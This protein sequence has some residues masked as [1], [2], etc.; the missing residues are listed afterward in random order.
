MRFLGFIIFF[1][2]FFNSF[3]Q[4]TFYKLYSGNG[5]DKGEGIVQLPD[6]SYVLTGSSG[7]FAEHNQTYLLAVDKAGNYM[8][9]KSY[10]GPE[11]DLGKRVLHIPNS[12]Y[13]IA[14]ISNSYGQGDFDAFLIKTD[15]NGQEEWIKNYEVP[16]SWEK[17]NDATLTLDSG[18]VMVGE[19]LPMSNGNSDIYLIRTDK[20]GDTLW[21]KRWGT[22]GNEFA[23]SIVNKGTGFI[24][25]GQWYISDSTLVK[26]LLLEIDGDGNEIWRDTI[27]DIDGSYSITDISISNSKIYV[28]GRNETPTKI[29]GYF[30]VFDLNG[31]LLNQY[32]QNMSDGKNECRQVVYNATLDKV[33]VSYHLLNPGTYQD[34]YDLVYAYFDSQFLYWMN[35]SNSVSNEGRDEVGQIIPTSDGGFIGVGFSHS[36]GSSA[37][38]FNGGSHIYLFKV[39]ASNVFPFTENVV[40]MNQLVSLNE[41]E[42]FNG[43]YYPNPVREK[44]FIEINTQNEQTYQ[45]F[46]LFGNQLQKGTITKQS[47]IDF[48]E[49]PKGIYLLKVGNSTFKVIKD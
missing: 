16:N 24:I 10:G 31:N 45:L 48:V 9:S 15:L 1:S 14:G 21:T 38:T 7:S 27:T 17:I 49:L 36:T 4:D 20:N 8:W 25:S 43:R 11:S 41:V 47:E 29:R 12:G 30:G 33:V 32:S 46:D 23:T 18:V 40:L 39:S 3:G 26:G 19:I 2:C 22:E 13:L 6:S 34:D 35:Q 37:F 5:F 44:L 42:T 28:V